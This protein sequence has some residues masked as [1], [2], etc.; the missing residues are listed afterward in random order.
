MEIAVAMGVLVG[1]FVL[2][3][4]LILYFPYDKGI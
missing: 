2:L 3:G 4:G 1:V